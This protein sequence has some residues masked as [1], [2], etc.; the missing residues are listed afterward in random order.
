MAFRRRDEGRF[1]GIGRAIGRDGPHRNA[2]EGV[3]YR[4]PG[5][6]PLG[7]LSESDITR[8]LLKREN[9]LRLSLTLA[10]LIL[11]PAAYAQAPR[12]FPAATHGKGELRYLEGVPVLVLSG[13]P[14]EMGGQFGRLAV[15]NAPDLDGLHA[16]FLKDSGQER[17]YPFI[18]G[19]ARALKPNIPPHMAA[20]LRAAGNA[21]GR[22]EG[23]LLFANTIADLTSGLGC[24]TL[25]VEPNRSRTG[26][27]L[28]GRNFDWQPTKGLTEHTLVVA[29]KGVGKRAFAAVTFSP[30]TGVVSGMNDV[31]LCVTINEVLLRKSKDKSTFNW[32]G[33]P[34]LYAFRQ[35]LEECGTVAEAEALL[36]A[37]PRT[38]SCCMTIC[39]T[40]GGAVFEMTPASLEVRPALGGVACCT[41]HFRTDKLR[42]ST[43]C[44]RYDRLRPL[45]HADGLLGVSDV[46]AQ[47]DGVHQGAA[48]LQSMVF[49]PSGRVLHLAYGEGPATRRTPK[50]LDLGRLFDAK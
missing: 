26:S 29:Y 46:F 23:L 11:P 16:R 12:T 28:F 35:V 17:R 14:E 41:N 1:W 40:S 25:V 30:V 37:V 27:P 43:D 15:A 18:V 4:R 31:G 19:M 7:P 49:E 22:E 6:I 38:T 47:L 24:S 8:P 5:L 21:A 48:T 34:L 10:F 36:R 2:T 39:D 9:A 50:R 44:W 42:L 32:R 3:P 33:T 13:T 45:Q 20:E